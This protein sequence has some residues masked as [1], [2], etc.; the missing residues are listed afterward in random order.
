MK[1]NN[2]RRAIVCYVDAK[3][4]LVSDF[5]CLHASFQALSDPVT[6]LVVFGPDEALRRL[7]SAC[8]KVELAP[9]SGKWSGYGFINSLYFLAAPEAAVI[10]DYAAVLRTDADTFVLPGWSDYRPA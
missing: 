1:V 6:D 10:D 5:R 9:R 2:G 4:H 7:P 3:A 8:I